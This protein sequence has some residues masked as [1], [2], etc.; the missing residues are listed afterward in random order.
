MPSLTDCRIAASRKH[1][2]GELKR[3][4]RLPA[5]HPQ[6]LIL[7]GRAYAQVEPVHYRAGGRKSRSYVAVTNAGSADATPIAGGLIICRDRAVAG[8][9][10]IVDDPS[11]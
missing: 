6:R 9:S 4:H 10:W 1:E 5:T 3:C 2:P 7:S 8:R 11:C